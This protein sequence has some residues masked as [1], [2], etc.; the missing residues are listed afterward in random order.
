MKSLHFFENHPNVTQSVTRC[1]QL[2][3]TLTPI[4][5]GVNVT[6]NCSTV[7]KKVLLLPI[8]YTAGNRHKQNSWFCKEIC[9]D[10]FRFWWRRV[11]EDASQGM[12]MSK[13]EICFFTA[14]ILQNQRMLCCGV[15]FHD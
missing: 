9:E 5:F 15:C 2:Y 14:Q 3:V 11:H 12:Y 4:L 13:I 6:Y 8:H 1:E 7:D 10:N